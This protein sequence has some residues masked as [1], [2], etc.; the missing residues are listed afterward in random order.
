MLKYIILL[1]FVFLGCSN[2]KQYSFIVDTD[3]DTS[4]IVERSSENPSIRIS[5]DGYLTH[6]ANIIINYHESKVDTNLKYYIPLFAGKI[7]LK[8]VPWDFYDDK[9][10]VTFQHLEN[11]KGKMT[12]KAIL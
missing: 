1:V 10:R 4:F 5:V 2:P 7:E 9:A 3:K 12:I 11:K 6:N 8:D